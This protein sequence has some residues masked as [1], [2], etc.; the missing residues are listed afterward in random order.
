[1]AAVQGK[2]ESSIGVV[3]ANWSKLSDQE[4]A[5]INNIKSV[6]VDDSKRTGVDVKT[7]TYN[8]KSSYITN[9]RS[10]TAWIASTVGHDAYHVTQSQ[11]GEVYNRE[12][13]PRL[14]HEANQFQ[15]G[16]GAKFGLT[17]SQIDYIKNDTHTLY[18]TPPY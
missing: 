1:L 3:N 10:T 17:Q 18:N 6:T 13:A 12:T 2:L 11:R 8:F 14:E 9:E 5:T 16:V 4:K 7:G 15:I